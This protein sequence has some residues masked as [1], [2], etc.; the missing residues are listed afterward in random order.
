MKILMVIIYFYITMAGARESNQ[1]ANNLSLHIPHFQSI[2]ERTEKNCQHYAM[3]WWVFYY[4]LWDSEYMDYFFPTDFCEYIAQSFEEDRLEEALGTISLNYQ[5]LNGKEKRQIVK[6]SGK[7]YFSAYYYVNNEKMDNANWY[8][9]HLVDENDVFI[10]EIYENGWKS[11]TFFNH[12]AGKGKADDPRQS[13]IAAPEGKAYFIQWEGYRY[14]VVSYVTDAK[15]KGIYIFDLAEEHLKMLGM[16]LDAAGTARIN[17]YNMLL[18]DGGKYPGG[19]S[20][21]YPK[22]MP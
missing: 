18:S 14:F 4:G 5:L 17:F 22:G 7:G 1:S 3:R 20:S 19:D 2:M 15:E 8:L 16:Y 6:D 11:Y 13:L 9:V 10:E 21:N 12:V